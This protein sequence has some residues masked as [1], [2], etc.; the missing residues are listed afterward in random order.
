[1]KLQALGIALVLGL[2]CSHGAAPQPAADPQAKVVKVGAQAPDGSLTQAS[3]TKI[4]LADVL[5]EH[6][7]NVVVFYRGFY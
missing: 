1:M 2:G 5:R 6:K 7:Q 3:G 4:A